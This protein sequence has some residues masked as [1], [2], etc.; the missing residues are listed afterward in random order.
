MFRARAARLAAAAEGVAAVEF[1]LVLPVLLVIYFGVVAVTVGINTDRKIALVSRTVS[2]LTGRATVVDD[3]AINDIIGAAA[4]VL[5]PYDP[6]GLEISVASV[7]VR[8]PSG[9]PNGTNLEARVCW[10]VGRQFT[11]S[12]S[13]AKPPTASLAQNAVI[14]PIPEGFKSPNSSFIITIVHQVY[15]PVVGESITGSINL[16]ETTPWPVRNVQEVP[17]TNVKTFKDTELNR[18]ATGKCLS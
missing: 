14:N 7:A 5:A 2:D 4:A 6:L 12:G 8:D 17:Y 16:I 3:A 10:S 1:A 18:A 11:A 15:R 9:A 13:V